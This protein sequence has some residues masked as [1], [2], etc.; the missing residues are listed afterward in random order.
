MKEWRVFGVLAGIFLFS[1]YV[2]LSNPK[3][4]RAI[5]EA[6]RMLQWYA[7]NHTLAC[8]VPALFIAGGMTTFL[9]KEAVLR[10]LG[11]KARK[12]EA[13][14]VASVAGT[15]LAV[16]SCSVLPMFTGIY[17][18]GAG[19]GPAST[20][21]YAG[22]ALNILAISL[23]ARV[24]GFELGLW[25]SLGAIL[26]GIL[27]GILMAVVFRRDEQEREATMIQ[28]LDPPPGRR[29]LWQTAAY[30]AAMMLF[31][32]FSDW[33][34]PGNVTVR[35]SDG[36]ILQAV[37]LQ[38]TANDI[39]FQIERPSGNLKV[40][41]KITLAKSEITSIQDVESWVMTVFHLKWYLAG[42]MG[43]GVMCM[44]W[45]WFERDEVREWMANTWEFTKLLV[46]LLFGGVFAVGFLSELL[47]ESQIAAWV[48]DNGLRSNLIASIVGCLFYFATLTE[49]PI[50]QAL[51]ERGMAQGPALALLLA[52]PALSLPSILVLR[53]V[54]GVKK[55]AMFTCL[56]VL[57]ATVAG[58][59]YGHMH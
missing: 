48:G 51:M 55:T 15:V 25:R 54:V 59:S 14:S 17:R 18:I 40:G 39:V 29:K 26:L 31:L 50:L 21:L 56:V 57:M 28:L 13:Y 53:S 19:L 43:M 1:Y 41:D 11:P 35:K 27:V 38:E 37:T 5:L 58:L 47:P 2:P 20:F 24:L 30:F 36:T 22:P 52:G 44:V 42:I 49:I 23:T 8:V 9:S 46:P 7:R 4:Q 34:N 3:I 12:A 10:H 33:Y 45:R 16:C 6:F 32:I